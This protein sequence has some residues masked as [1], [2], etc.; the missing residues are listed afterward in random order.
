MGIEKHFLIQILGRT[1][2][3]TRVLRT[4][5]SQS[6]VLEA[7]LNSLKRGLLTKV[8]AHSAHPLQAPTWPMP[9]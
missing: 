6:Y 9:D 4:G 1:E 8:L 3:Q 5:G 2:E 7:L